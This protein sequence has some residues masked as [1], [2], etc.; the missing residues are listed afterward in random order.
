MSEIRFPNPV[1]S[2]PKANINATKISH[3]VLFENPDKPHAKTF[4][5]VKTPEAGNW[6][7]TFNKHAI[8]TPKR[9]I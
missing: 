3:T 6:G 7:P 8:T 1:F 9:P 4:S 5:E 2:Y